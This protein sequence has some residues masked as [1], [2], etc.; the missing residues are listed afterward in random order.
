[1]GR[2]LGD[3]EG[4]K[5]VQE[6][7]EHLKQAAKEMEGAPPPLRKEAGKDALPPEQRALQRLLAADAIFREVQVAFGN[8]SSGG[9]SGGEREQQELAG[10]FELELDKMKNQ[11]ETVQRAQQQQAE[12]QKS[13]A[14]RRLGSC[15]SA[16][17]GAR[18]Q[19]RRQQ[20]GAANGG[21][22]NQ[23]QQQELIDETRKAARELGTSLAR[24]SRRANAGVE[25]PAQS[26]CRRNA[27]SAGSGA[28][29]FG[30]V[31]LTK[32]ARA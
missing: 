23:R 13:E 20:Q 32:R 1:M 3:I 17:A 29:K 26:N 31:D 27:E 16:A 12:Q 9:G 4:Q 6:M 15:A 21:S 18:R 10:L 8:Q 19:R 14:E 7:A 22:G 11:Y 30:R 24:A 25:S 28:W 5:Q 2:R